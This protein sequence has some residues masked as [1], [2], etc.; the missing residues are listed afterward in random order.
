MDMGEGEKSLNITSITSPF[1]T[2]LFKFERLPYIFI[3]VALNPF[4]PLPPPPPP[5]LLPPPPPPPR[6]L[7]GVVFL[8]IGFELPQAQ[9]SACLCIPSA[10]IKH[11]CSAESI[12]LICN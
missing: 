1:P 6:P 7:T 2:I 5:P 3:S 8:K 4:L 9:R 11:V 12:F 10:R